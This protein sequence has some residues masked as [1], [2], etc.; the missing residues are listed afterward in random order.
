M[1]KLEV[2]NA[3]R[4]ARSAK[5]DTKWDFDQDSPLGYCYDIILREEDCGGYSARVA[6]LRGVVSQGDSAA[7]AMKNIIEALRAT[8]ETYR[9]EKMAIPWGGAEALQPGEDSF[10]VAVN[11]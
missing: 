6:R 10:R 7:E 11:V 3:S 1:T 5:F 2:Q 9:D 8:L 4:P